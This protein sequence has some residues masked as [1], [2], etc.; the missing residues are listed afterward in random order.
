MFER[1]LVRSTGSS[2]TDTVLVR[3]PIRI[4]WARGTDPNIS[5]S[6]GV[7]GLI[8]PN[9]DVPAPILSS[10]PSWLSSLSPPDSCVP[11]SNELWPITT[12]SNS[13]NSSSQHSRLPILV[14]ELSMWVVNIVLAWKWLRL[15]PT[16][17]AIMQSCSVTLF[18]RIWT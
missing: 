8:F 7:N 2:V 12:R 5:L 3:K 17:W 4:Y 14:C 13:P 16:S 1:S 6:V 15:S 11:A 18:M 9:R 10:P